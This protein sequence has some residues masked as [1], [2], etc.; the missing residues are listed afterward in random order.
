MLDEFPLLKEKPK[1]NESVIINLDKS[2]GSG[3]HWV[4]YKKRGN[5][6]EYY[7]S[8]GNLKPPKE[9]IKYLLKWNKRINIRYNR[10]RYQK[11]N[12]IICGHLCLKFLK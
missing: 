1:E 4:S 11:L 12:D 6:V 8:F 7:D 3:T 2:T 10:Q 5:T 9:L